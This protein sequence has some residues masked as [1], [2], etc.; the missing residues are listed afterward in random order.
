MS[1]IRKIRYF[2]L[3]ITERSFDL[4]RMQGGIQTFGEEYGLGITI[5]KKL[6]KLTEYRFENKRNEITIIL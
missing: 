5:L 3:D 1:F 4:M 2:S 6:G